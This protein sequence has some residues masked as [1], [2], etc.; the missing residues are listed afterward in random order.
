LHH[1][2]GEKK[3]IGFLIPTSVV[4]V[5]DFVNSPWFQLLMFKN[6]ITTGPV[7]FW[8]ISKSKNHQ[9]SLFQK[10][11][12][13]ISIKELVKRTM[14]FWLVLSEFLV[15]ENDSYIQEAGSLVF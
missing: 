10:P 1:K 5:F 13:T 9:F 3:N 6:K 2:I 4:Q 14:V 11:K 15:K 8:K 7:S 12:N